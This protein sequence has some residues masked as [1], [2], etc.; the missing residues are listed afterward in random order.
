[1]LKGVTE[2]VD[3]IGKDHFCDSLSQFCEEAVQAAEIALFYFPDNDDPQ[4]LSTDVRVHE[5]VVEYVE[6]AYRQDANLQ[7][8]YSRLNDENDFAISSLHMDQIR[9]AGYMSKFYK[10]KIWLIISG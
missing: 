3:A 10:I 1:M 8:L 2:I 5:A 7:G 4:C 6:G 9:D